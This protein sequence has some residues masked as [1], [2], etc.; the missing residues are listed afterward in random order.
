MTKQ[1]IEQL[2]CDKAAELIENN[3][4]NFIQEAVVERPEVLD[5]QYND[6]LPHKIEA[7]FHDWLRDLWNKLVPDGASLFEGIM[8]RHL[9]RC[10][11]D[12]DY[13]PHLQEART[14][15]EKV[16]PWEKILRSNHKDVTRYKGM[17]KDYSEALLENM[18]K[19]FVE[20]FD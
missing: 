18:I 5:P 7:E 11:V 15:A 20:E 1:E 19:D 3:F 14:D 8:N 17:L 6:D 4:P 13:K 2:C 9:D 16:S 10:M 12:A